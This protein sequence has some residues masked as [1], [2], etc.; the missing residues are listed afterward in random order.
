MSDK[1][2]SVPTNVITGFLGVGKTSAIKHLLQAKPESERWAVLVNEFGEIGIDGGL[3]IGAMDSGGEQ[4]VFIREVPGGCMCCASGVPMQI[5]LNQLLKTARPHRLLIEPT[6]L[7]HPREVM[8]VLNSAQYKQVLKL[9][10]TLTLVDARHLAD[11]RYTEHDTFLQQ[12]DIADVIVGNKTDLYQVGDEKAL[13]DFV[14]KRAK[15]QG[16][17]V[18]TENAEI[19]PDWLTVRPEQAEIEKGAERKP[20]P[21][22]VHQHK[23]SENTHHHHHHHSHHEHEKHNGK[24]ASERA[25]PESGIVSAVNEGEG[26]QSIGWRFTKQHVFDYEP[27]RELIKSIESPN[28]IRLKATFKTSQGCWGYNNSQDGFNEIPLIDIEESRIEIIG[29]QIESMQQEWHE[30]LKQLII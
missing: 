9:E 6:G 20:Q 14:E 11:P 28:V 4:Q 18:F 1:I 12:L 25:F 13:S 24:L 29:Q 21:C 3:F 22:C 16:M 17:L 10:N 26:F 8:E 23:H 19:T 2:L 7:G 30:K 5:A 15:S 27:L